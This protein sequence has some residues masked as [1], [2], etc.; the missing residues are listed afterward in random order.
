[1]ARAWL[2]GE[3]MWQEKVM[4]RSLT[5]GTEVQ[6]KVSFRTSGKTTSKRPKAQM[7]ISDE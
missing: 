2:R 5:E 1:V 3:V 6:E 4:F 7:T